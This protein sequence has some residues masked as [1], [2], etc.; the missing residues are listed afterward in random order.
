[1]GGGDLHSPISDFTKS[2]P[3]NKKKKGG[4][5]GR[6]GELQWSEA[7][8]SFYNTM[9]FCEMEVLDWKLEALLSFDLYFIQAKLQLM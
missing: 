6:G 3:K 5:E 9:S 7:D 4:G 8:V 1:M 2:S